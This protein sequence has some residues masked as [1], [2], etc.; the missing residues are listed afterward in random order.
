MRPPKRPW[1]HAEY[2][3][4]LL[5]PLLA[6]QAVLCDNAPALRLCARLGSSATSSAAPEDRTSLKLNA[7]PVARTARIA[8]IGGGIGGLPAA[9]ALLRRGFEVRVYE[10]PPSSKRSAPGS[11]SVP[12]R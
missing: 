6:E 2:S 12:M 7:G 8:L 4:S 10:L 1:E 5:Y 3:L 9:R 11:R